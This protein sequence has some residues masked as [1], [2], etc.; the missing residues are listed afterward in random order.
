MAE[1]RDVE[2]RVIAG[3]DFSFRQ[4][5]GREAV[6]EPFAHEIELLC[7]DDQIRLESVLGTTLGLE[8]T[9]DDRKVRHIH[10]HVTRFAYAGTSG[11][12]ARYR[13]RLEPWLALLARHRDQRIFQGLSVPDIV[14]RIFAKHKEARHD[15]R[16][17]A[18][19]PARDYCVQYGETD[20]D[21]VERLLEEEGIFYFFEHK[22]GRHELV[23]IDDVAGSAAAEGYA[24][25]P[26]FPREAQA[27]RERDHLHE[28]ES[29]LA[30]CPGAAVMRSFDFTKPTADLEVRER[31]LAGHEAA[32]GEVFLF[33]DR[34]H[35]TDR[36]KTLARIRLEEQQAGHARLIGQGNAAGLAAGGRFRLTGYPRRDQN[37][38]YFIIGVEHEIKA[39]P[40]RSGA[41]SDD[42][43]PYSCR[44]EVQPLD[45]PFR[46]PRRHAKPLVAGPETAMVT[47]PSG[48]E[49][50]TDEHGRVKVR[51]HWDRLGAKDDRS[52]CWI[53]VSQAWAGPG[54][55]AITIPRIGQEV[56]VDF[57]H[58]DPDQPLVT[59][60]VYNGLAR[61]PYGLPG[62]KTQSGLKSNSSKGGGGSNELRFEDAKGSEEVYL[63]AEKDETIRVENDKAESVGHDEAIDIGNDRSET[64][65]NDETLSVGN[66][67][68]REVK[69]DETVSVGNDQSI[70]VTGNQGIAVGGNRTDTVGANEARTVMVAQ[71]QTVGAARTVSVG[72]AQSHQ[73]GA[74][75]GW[76]VAG[77]R[78]V[79][80]AKGQSTRIGKD[81]SASIG[82]NE[83]V[84][85]AE[86][87]TISIG[88]KLS[89]TAGE[90]ITIRTGQASITMKKDGTI[91]I[92]GKDLKLEGSGKI[93]VKASKTIT[94]KGRKI[95]QN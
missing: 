5:R 60:R 73:I 76:V 26:F 57:L 85:V 75:D 41:A 14:K 19:Y 88:K 11:S 32:G 91:T 22:E 34:Y 62:S 80:I 16:L 31:R 40:L 51:F 84:T 13:A 46:P 54:F 71:Q 74:D 49:I 10:G 23:L 37:R 8:V 15:D 90:E 61:P 30:I 35:D 42:G 29:A 65:G 6:S 67:R 83:A 25:V 53:R 12:F 48:E 27:R 2:V 28:W 7:E 56:V 38:D 4:L 92:K 50:H 64:V 94:M 79:S 21:F 44:I 39:D 52:S 93:D 3:H 66:N 17:T 86:D 81:R 82:G 36:G 18:S 43:E 24:E 78:S 45:R 72:A 77:D 9:V 47:G 20:L 33:P 58:G 68:S 95:L 59:G 55:G 63:H 69:A 70:T 89:I 1:E 87:A